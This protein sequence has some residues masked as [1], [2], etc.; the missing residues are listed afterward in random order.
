[1]IRIYQKE[2]V[3]DENAKNVI[4]A[5]VNKNI[6]IASIMIR[7]TPIMETLT[8]YDRRFYI[9]LRKTNKFWGNSD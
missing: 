8:V 3:E 7:A 6:R 9:L 4:S 2:N 1:M 5:L